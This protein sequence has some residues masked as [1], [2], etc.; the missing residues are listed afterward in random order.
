MTLYEF[1]RRTLATRSMCTRDE[2]LSIMMDD[3]EVAQRLA[4]SQG[5]SRLLNNMKQSGF[6]ELEGKLI[7][8]TKR[9]VGKRRA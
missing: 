9:R 7:R 8:R 2:L 3:Q 6:I 1:V 4:D 5:F